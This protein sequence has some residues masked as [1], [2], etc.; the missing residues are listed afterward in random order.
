MNLVNLTYVSA[1]SYRATASGVECSN[2]RE[3]LWF[4]LASNPLTQLVY[5]TIWAIPIALAVRHYVRPTERREFRV[6]PKRVESI[7]RERADD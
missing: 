6:T 3:A 1:K 2:G 5:S 4:Y 7:R